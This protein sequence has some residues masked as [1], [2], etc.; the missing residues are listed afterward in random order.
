MMKWNQYK[1]DF[2]EL[3]GCNNINFIYHFT[4]LSNLN[5][6]FENEHLFSL[7]ELHDRNIIFNTSS[8]DLSKY[9]DS[10]KHTTDYVR[11]TFTLEN[12][13]I[14]KFLSRHPNDNF[15][16]L[17]LNILDLKNFNDVIFSN[18]N[19][20]D[21]NAIFF[22]NFSNF[23]N[24][25]F[26]AF[27]LKNIKYGMLEFK[28]SQ[29]EILIPKSVHVQYLSLHEIIIQTKKELLWLNDPFMHQI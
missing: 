12:P 16:A 19:A 8:N 24:L 13:L 9:L 23:E 29:A 25:D 26:K 1:K 5:S 3:L 6:I 20:T 7:K 22:N 15:C 14:K 21:K 28:T 27:K 18:I 11:F 4:K 17:K 2:I 10:G